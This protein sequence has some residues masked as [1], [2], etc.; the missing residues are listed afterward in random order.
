MSSIEAQIRN[1]SLAEAQ[2]QENM[3]HLEVYANEENRTKVETKRKALAESEN[4]EQGMQSVGHS[5]PAI[6]NGPKLVKKK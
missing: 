6:P 4:N 2:L 5:V 3:I 1:I